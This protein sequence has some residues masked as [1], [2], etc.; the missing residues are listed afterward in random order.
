M[1]NLSDVCLAAAYFRLLFQHKYYR[2]ITLRNDTLTALIHPKGA[3]LQSLVHTNG[4]QYMWSGDATYWGKRSPVLFPIVGSLKNDTYFFGDKSYTLPRHGFARDMEFTS[5]KI[6]EKEAVFTLTDSEAT[7]AVYPF[8][9]TLKLRYQ[10]RGSRLLCTYEVSNTGAAEMYFSVGGHPA[11]A[12]PLVKGTAYTDYSLLFSKAEPLYRYKLENGLTSDA[13]E[14]LSTI[15]CKPGTENAAIKLQLTP[16]LFYDDA[17]VLK[18]LQN[19]YTTLASNKH[20]HGL[21]F[22]FTGFPYLGIWAAKDAPFVCIE[23]WCGITDNV[24]HNQQLT[25]KE[26]IIALKTGG[27]WQRSWSVT[28][29]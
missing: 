26:G 21:Q 2:M 23:P 13:R 18:H 8:P 4:I 19:Y 27:S 5:K 10:L 22:D 28:C 1:P 9:F 7:R 12:L 29:F 11:F 3:E 14:L 17:I 25:E 24:N 16:A 15:A 20:E 6:N